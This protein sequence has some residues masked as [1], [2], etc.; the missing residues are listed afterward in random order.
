L[1]IDPRSGGLPERM[2]KGQGLRL[3]EPLRNLY[4]DE[5]RGMFFRGVAV[6]ID[7]LRVVEDRWLRKNPTDGVQHLG[8]NLVSQRNS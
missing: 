8:E 7:F 1:L 2:S 4:K 3:I 6:L 5:V